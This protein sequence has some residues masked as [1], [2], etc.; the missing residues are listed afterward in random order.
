MR[1]GRL[2][3]PFP[4]RYDSP[5]SYFVIVAP[6]AED[7]ADVAAFVDWLRREAAAQSHADRA[8]DAKVARPRPSARAIAQGRPFMN[9]P[10][11]P[12]AVSSPSPW[13]AR[14]AHLVPAGAR[15]LDVACGYGRH[16]LVFA[17]RGAH[18][19][20]VDRDATAL[21]TLSGKA[22]IETRQA[23]LEAR[24]VAAGR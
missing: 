10:S 15:V 14:F 6:H 2:V 3:A 5:R 11:N 23:D 13:I 21:A 17:A 7:R 16:A 1:D 19:V 9:T 4:K 8:P 12:H 20:A 22:G 24:P 18:V